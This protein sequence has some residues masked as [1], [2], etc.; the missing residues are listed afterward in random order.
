ML[1][2]DRKKLKKGKKMKNK[3]FLLVILGMLLFV[4]GCEATKGAGKDIENTGQNVQEG[5]ERL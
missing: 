1:K 5:M 2:S 4:V 3:K